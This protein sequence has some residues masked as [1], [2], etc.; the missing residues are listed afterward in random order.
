MLKKEDL[1][2]VV[3]AATFDYVPKNI[4]TS[5]I[6]A[7]APHGSGIDAVVKLR[8]K[9]TEAFDTLGVVIEVVIDSYMCGNK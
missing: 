8:D 7:K 1:L 5:V 2:A 3:N 6:K 9:V 4:K